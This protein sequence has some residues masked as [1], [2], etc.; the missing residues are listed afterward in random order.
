MLARSPV[1]VLACPVISVVLEIAGLVLLPLCIPFPSILSQPHGAEVSAA[2]V[3]RVTT[4]FASNHA[5][6]LLVSRPATYRL[7]FAVMAHL[8]RLLSAVRLKL[9]FHTICF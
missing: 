4:T 9:S 2:G 5:A 1:P 3:D 8:I 6:C 7:S